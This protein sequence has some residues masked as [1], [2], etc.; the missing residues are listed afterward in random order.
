[1]CRVSTRMWG[2]LPFPAQLLHPVAWPPDLLG[3]GPCVCCGPDTSSPW[4][5]DPGAP[6]KVCAVFVW[7]GPWPSSQPPANGGGCAGCM[8]AEKSCAFLSVAVKEFLMRKISNKHSLFEIRGARAWSGLAAMGAVPASSSSCPLLVGAAVMTGPDVG[9][10][11][12]WSP[13]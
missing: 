4:H 5:E 6:V 9:D 11:G 2:G 3:I 7:V 13:G 8:S 12:L 10:S 1:M